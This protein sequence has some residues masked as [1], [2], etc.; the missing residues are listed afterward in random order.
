MKAGLSQGI[1]EG[2]GRV[3]G[4]RRR[5]PHK[6]Q[7]YVQSEAGEEVLKMPV[8]RHRSRDDECFC[9]TLAG[10]WSSGIWSNTI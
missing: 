1:K 2:G 10:V 6:T 3:Y 4:D 8:W 9:V 7:V 5:K